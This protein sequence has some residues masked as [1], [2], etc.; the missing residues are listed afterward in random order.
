[1]QIEVKLFATFRNHLPPGSGPFSSSIE[2]ET[3][4]TIRDVLEHFRIPE[5]TPKILL[6]NGLHARPQDVLQEGDVLSVFPPL[7]GG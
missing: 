5:D 4:Q 1:M 2:V 3:G 7:A 6:V